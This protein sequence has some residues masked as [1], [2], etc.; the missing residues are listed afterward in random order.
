MDTDFTSLT[1]SPELR[2]SNGIFF[3]AAT[4]GIRAVDGMIN[5]PHSLVILSTVYHNDR[6]ALGWGGGSLSL[7]LGLRQT[8]RSIAFLLPGACLLCFTC[9]ARCAEL[10]SGG[11]ACLVLSRPV[12][13]RPAYPAYPAYLAYCYPPACLCLRRDVGAWRLCREGT[14]GKAASR[15]LSV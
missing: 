14:R 10:E 12:L 4:F 1:W 15:R 13:S 9:F 5:A 7:Q 2:I 3:P 11:I 6:T 8:K